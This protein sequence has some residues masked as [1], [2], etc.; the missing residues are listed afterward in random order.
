MEQ[1]GFGKVRLVAAIPVYM[2]GSRR[3]LNA[4]CFV[5]DQMPPAATRKSRATDGPVAQNLDLSTMP[6]FS[7]GDVIG[8][9]ASQATDRAAAKLQA[10]SDSAA[11]I[12]ADDTI[13]S[14]DSQRPQR[15]IASSR[16]KGGARSGR[17]EQPESCSMGSQISSESAAE[18]SQ[19][20]YGLRRREAA[21]S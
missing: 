9:L 3:K 12:A 20:G 8:V 1:L 7:P 10:A 19:H 15:S 16:S 2:A 17:S 14:R 4:Y 5:R 13:S 6:G 18:S 11:N 21:R